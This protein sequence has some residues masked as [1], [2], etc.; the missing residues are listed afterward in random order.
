[1]ESE[2]RE[3]NKTV[4]QKNTEVMVL[5]ERSTTEYFRATEK[6]C[7]KNWFFDLTNR[8]QIFKF[9]LTINQLF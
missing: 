7:K 8:I 6:V 1:M 2:L 4:E 9:F 5:T 3:A